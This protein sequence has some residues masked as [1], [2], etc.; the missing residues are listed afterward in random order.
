MRQLR[1]DPREQ[2]QASAVQ[3]M[4]QTVM[5][6]RK[7]SRVAQQHFIDAARRRVAVE[8]SQYIGIED[9]AQARQCRS[10]ALDNAQGLGVDIR[11]VALAVASHV[12]KLEAGLGEQ[13]SQ[14]RIEGVP[15]IEVFTFLAQVHGPQAHRE[16]RPAQLLEDVP[17]GFTR[18]QLAAA[19]FA[20][21]TTIAA[22]PF[23]PGSTQAGDDALQLPMPCLRVFAHGY[24]SCHGGGYWKGRPPDRRSLYGKSPGGKK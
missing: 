9:A 18:R 24:V 10:K 6:D 20:T 4:G 12:A 13:G 19:L 22:A 21:A 3:V 11:H 15:D 14:G 1:T 2:R 8:G 16:Q 17:H 5:D 7:N 23:V